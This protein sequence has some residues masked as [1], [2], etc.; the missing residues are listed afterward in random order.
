MEVSILKK[1]FCVGKGY[2]HSETEFGMWKREGM[3]YP[4]KRGQ[5]LRKGCP[6]HEGGFVGG[7]AS[8]R[9][10]VY[11]LLGP[12]R[13]GVPIWGKEGQA[14]KGALGVKE[15]LA[16][17]GWAGGRGSESTGAC[18]GAAASRGT[19]AVELVPS[20]GAGWRAGPGLYVEMARFPPCAG[21][22]GFPAVLTEAAG[23]TVHLAGKAP[24][25]GLS[26]AGTSFS[27]PAE[28]PTLS[29][30]HSRFRSPGSTPSPRL[31][32]PPVRRPVCLPWNT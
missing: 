20:R 6:N 21:E 30:T 27:G 9:E 12:L 22:G 3:L 23:E 18:R 11:Q 29:L 13:E 15:G 17:E 2:Y 8:V 14:L 31:R 5:G 4:E 7:S 28:W 25:S 16:E 26:G 24:R 10:E 19:C 1:S 32:R